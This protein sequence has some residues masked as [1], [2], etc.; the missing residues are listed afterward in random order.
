[1]CFSLLFRGLACRHHLIV[2][3]IGHGHGHPNGHLL[4]QMVL[5][6][7]ISCLTAKWHHIPQHHTLNTR[8]LITLINTT[9]P[10]KRRVSFEYGTAFWVE[11]DDNIS[12]AW[13]EEAENLQYIVSLIPLF[14]ASDTNTALSLH[15]LS[16]LV[17]RKLLVH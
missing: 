14:D 7:A 1:M 2:A 12:R 11:S 6:L 4:P 17:K 13:Y 15:F 9:F 8:N 16:V 10:H 3:G 5:Q